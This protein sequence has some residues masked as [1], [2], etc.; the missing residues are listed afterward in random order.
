MQCSAAIGSE[1]G[2]SGEK[3]L[4]FGRPVRMRRRVVNRGS[5]ASYPRFR[6]GMTRV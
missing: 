6:F 1:S 2:T 5:V 4:K 3:C